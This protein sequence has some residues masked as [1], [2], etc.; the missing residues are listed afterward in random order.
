MCQERCGVGIVPLC[1]PNDG[2]DVHGFQIAWI[3]SD[4]REQRLFRGLVLSAQCGHAAQHTDGRPAKLVADRL[5]LL[6]GNRSGRGRRRQVT[7]RVARA[8]L[9]QLGLVLFRG[10]VRDH[11]QQGRI[12]RHQAKRPLAPLEP[13]C[14]IASGHACARRKIVGLFQQNRARIQL[15]KTDRE[16]PLPSRLRRVPYLAECCSLARI[17][18]LIENRG[19]CLTVTRRADVLRGRQTD[20]EKERER[21]RR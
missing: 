9:G 5:P 21:N 11:D 6:Q 2:E 4:G 14:E 8:G 10:N 1:D 20:R 18:D 3:Q 19:R 7:N 15:D 16:I 12:L 17:R 13:S